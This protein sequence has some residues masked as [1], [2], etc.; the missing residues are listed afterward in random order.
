MFLLVRNFELQPAL[1]YYIEGLNCTTFV[2]WSDASVF[3]VT[4]HYQVDCDGQ[5]SWRGG[6]EK[7][8]KDTAAQRVMWFREVA[9]ARA[10]VM[11]VVLTSVLAIIHVGVC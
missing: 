4:G 1:Y 11:P 7:G 2:L 3:C 5:E 8:G 6:G 9:I 10:I